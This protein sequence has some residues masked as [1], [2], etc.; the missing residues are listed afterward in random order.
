MVKVVHVHFITKHKNYYF[1]SVRAVY[2]KFSSSDIGC[3]EEYLRHKLTYDGACYVN[4]I[5]LVIRGVLQS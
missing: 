5:V 2:K 3:S 1:S 4:S